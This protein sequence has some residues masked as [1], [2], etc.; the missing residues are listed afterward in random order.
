MKITTFLLMVR[1][2][3][4]AKCFCEIHAV[5]S[6]ISVHK[7]KDGIHTHTT[8]KPTKQSTEWQSMK[9]YVLW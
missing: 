6:Y 8:Y 9:T 1:A 3:T 5:F 7:S 4:T 2:Y